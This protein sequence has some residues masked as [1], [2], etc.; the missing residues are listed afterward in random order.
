MASTVVVVVVV[1]GI[2][3]QGDTRVHLVC[4]SE[5]CGFLYKWSQ[6]DRLYVNRDSIRNGGLALLDTTRD[7]YIPRV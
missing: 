3:V 6:T 2:L 7:C 1:V 5:G 4:N